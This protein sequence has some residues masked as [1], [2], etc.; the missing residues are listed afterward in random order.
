ME[1]KGPVSV[2]D[3]LRMIAIARVVM[4]ASIV[5]LRAGRIA[6]SNFEQVLCFLTGANSIFT[7][8]KLLTTANRELEEDAQLIEDLRLTG[9]NPYSGPL[10]ERERESVANVAQVG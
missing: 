2:S 1:A 3:L 9:Q 8:D 5:R 6:R 7:R 4:T 10:R